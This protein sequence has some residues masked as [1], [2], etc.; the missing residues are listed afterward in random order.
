MKVHT[1]VWLENENGKL[2]VGQGRLKIFH[3]IARTGSLS[4]AAREL[5]MSY[6]AVWGKVRATEERLGLK[7]VDGV[8]GGHK[9][10]GATLTSDAI[11]FV[12]RFEEFNERAVQLIEELAAEMLPDDFPSA[13][14]R[15]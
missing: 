7:L 8:A 1:K 12:K 5:N 10:G 9:H 14:P 13:G 4:A 15:S 3:A 11:E 2:L 6:R